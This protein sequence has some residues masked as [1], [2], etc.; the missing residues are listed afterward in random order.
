ML[1]AILENHEEASR[2][3]SHWQRTAGA[4]LSL[5]E[6]QARTEADILERESEL[7]AVLLT[8]RILVEFA[9]CACPLDGGQPPGALDLGRL[10]VAASLI[11]H[12]GG[13]SDAIR[14][15]VME[16]FIQITSFG[17]V[18]ANREFGD[19]IVDPYAKVMASQRLKEAVESYADSV[20]PP[21]REEE[22]AASERD[23]VF[24]SAIVEA[25]GTDLPVIGAF[26]HHLEGLAMAAGSPVVVAP[27]SRLLEVQDLDAA[28][29]DQLAALVDALIFPSR[30]SWRELPPGYEA[31][32]IQPWRFRRRLTI[33]RRPLLEI[34]CVTDPE[35]IFA[36]AQVREAIHY[37]LG[38]YRRGDFNDAQLGPLM[39][40]WKKSVA[41]RRGKRFSAVVAKV[42]AEQGWKTDT[43]VKITELLG[44]KLDRDYGDVDVLAWDPP[45][46]RIMLI[47]C[48]DLQYRKTFGEFAEQ[49]ADFRGEFRSNG[50]PDYLLRHLDRVAIARR[51]LSEICT[52]LKIKDGSLADGLVFQNSVPMQ[53]AAEHI[54]T[55]DFYTLGQ[56]ES[57]VFRLDCSPP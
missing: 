54:K 37:M 46:G 16:P 40:H 27:K 23:Q 44:R 50:K 5:H 57:G 53:F 39:A 41:D 29:G 30:L 31:R 11:F 9:I 49:L 42:L 13:D 17:D 12:S 47:E 34:E 38:N 14:W 6:D 18:H 8:S 43:E 22:E 2:E 1:R 20:R 52:H 56:V 55:R 35:L 48:K 19:Q 32:D 45:S 25:F 28:K 10:M 15:D 33:L 3:L 21:E 7:N 26:L 24:D 51:R 4:V 36:P